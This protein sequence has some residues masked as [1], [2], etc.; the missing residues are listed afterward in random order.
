MNVRVPTAG[1]R[2][3][4]KT[5]PQNRWAEQGSACLPKH[6]FL[7]DSGRPQKDKNQSSGFWKPFCQL[8]RTK[9]I[10]ESWLGSEPLAFLPKKR[11]EACPNPKKSQT[12][13]FLAISKTILRA[14]TRNYSQNRVNSRNEP[15]TKHFVSH[16]TFRKADKCS[17]TRPSR[18]LIKSATNGSQRPIL[19]C[20]RQL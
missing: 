16:L 10:R 7:R 6:G 8:S 17:N 20:L 5:K 13:T 12:A 19:T 9:P 15:E 14:L 4:L 2:F 11:P 18:A 1:S 3:W